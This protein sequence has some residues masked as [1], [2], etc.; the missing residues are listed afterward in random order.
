MANN[1]TH[2]VVGGI[3]GFIVTLVD[4][5]SEVKG[6]PLNPLLSTGIAT[7]FGKLPD[8][9]EP[10]TNPHH[11]QFCHSMVIL[12]GISYGLKKTYN[13]KPQDQSERLL[14]KIVLCA[15]AGYVSHLL[16]E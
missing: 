14:R 9:L 13:W 12:A 10:A 1:M 16:L 5:N 7:L 3:S 6:N 8:I 11:R 4:N 15:G 2:S